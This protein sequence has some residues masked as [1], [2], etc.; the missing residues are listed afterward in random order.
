M[1]S[2]LALDGGQSGIRTLFSDA[3]GS[4]PGPSFTGIRSDQPLL[5]Q[6]SAIVASALDGAGVD[7]VALGLSGLGDTDTA[8]E[9]HRL[10][11]DSAGSVLLAH[12]ATTSFLGALG[13]REGAVVASG[14][15]AV[16]LA[17]GPR[18]VRRVDGWGHLLGDAGSGFWIGR[19]ALSAVLRAHDGRG[20]AT[21]LTGRA[22]DEFGD[23]NQLYLQLQADP[24]HVA[25]IASWARLVSALAASDAVCER[26]SRA[27]GQEL[28]G[29]A[30]SGLLS[31]DAEKVVGSVGN[32]F[33]NPLVASSF[34]E[35][36]RTLLP[37]VV[38]VP[39]AGSGLDG[40]ALLVDV[41]PG[42]AIDAL[43]DR[44]Q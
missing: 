30:V 12:D 5:T 33:L 13:N 9:L 42:S 10:L 44:A 40:A 15:G 16:T 21:A 43:V 37:D 20:P 22:E 6:V 26:I 11:G 23:L 35:E 17:V 28:A 38:V 36:L 34:E 18:S 31:V 41:E 27:A 4:H 32:V 1:T 8:D 24:G 2:V 7:V 3:F 25:R 29:S 19:Q 14:T 39:A